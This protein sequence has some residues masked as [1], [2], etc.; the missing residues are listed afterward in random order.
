M[1]SLKSTFTILFLL[2][3]SYGVYRL[4]HTPDPLVTRDGQFF[5]QLTPLVPTQS[6]ST[7]DETK[8]K[9]LLNSFSG[10]IPN[11][12]S[13]EK[14]SVSPTIQSE[15]VKNNLTDAAAPP[16][17]SEKISPPATSFA[18]QTIKPVLAPFPSSANPIP[19]IAPSTPTIPVA[20][21]SISAPKLVDPS[22]NHPSIMTG[23]LTPVPSPSTAAPN[24]ALPIA[25]PTTSPV[26][27]P[28]IVPLVAPTLPSTNG[29][30]QLEGTQTLTDLKAAWPIVDSHIRKGE[31]AQSL[32]VLSGYYHA[33]LSDADRVEL[34]RWLDTLASKVIYST[35]HQLSPT[36]HIVQ[37]AETVESIAKQWNIPPDLLLNIN[38]SK[39]PENN[40]LTPGLELKIVRGPFRAEIDSQRKELTLFLDQCYAGRF[41]IDASRCESLQAGTLSVKNF[42]VDATG[43]Y[44]MEFANGLSVCTANPGAAKDSIQLNSA[45]AKDVF[46]ILTA[47]SQVTVVR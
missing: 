34:L 24:A 5:V 29:M 36:P 26:T 22:A 35:E 19:T 16:W 39:I 8:P 38:R 44:T 31:I 27:M 13:A 32:N 20:A 15:V 3:V 7:T 11:L 9:S 14:K 43:Q 30:R 42:A 47:N 2:G 12:T 6:A 41:P 37:A 33:N 46:G 17:D 23:P 1:N 21:P 25:A 10:T 40:V 18:N 28:K 4:I 45:D